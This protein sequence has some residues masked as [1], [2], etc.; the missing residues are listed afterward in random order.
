MLLYRS[1]EMRDPASSEHT[2]TIQTILSHRQML[3]QILASCNNWKYSTKYL[4]KFHAATRQL[5]C[6]TWK[7][8]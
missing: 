6:F 7:E 5:E 2:V 4:M 3:D 1:L 8:L